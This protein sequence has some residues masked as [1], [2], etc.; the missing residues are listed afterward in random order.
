VR[1][2]SSFRGFT[3]LAPDL[4]EATLEGTEPDGLSLEKL[5]RAPVER[6]EQLRML[7]PRPR[8]LGR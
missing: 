7:G 2:P 6:E 5:Y 1:L 8:G 4:I 3:L